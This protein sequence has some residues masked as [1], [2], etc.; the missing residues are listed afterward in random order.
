MWGSMAGLFSALI[1]LRAFLEI[2][3][4]ERLSQLFGLQSHNSLSS[5]LSFRTQRDFSLHFFIYISNLFIYLFIY[6]SGLTRPFFLW[7]HL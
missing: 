1:P 5:F 6:K 7:Y 4:P 3:Y 2:D